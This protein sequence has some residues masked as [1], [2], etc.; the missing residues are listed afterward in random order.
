MVTAILPSMIAPREPA[1]SSTPSR[2]SM[3]IDSHIG[4]PSTSAHLPIT[5]LRLHDHASRSVSPSKK[6]ATKSSPTRLAGFV[7]LFTG[8]GALLALGVFLPLPAIFQ[9]SGLQPGNA[10]VKSYYIVG[11][12]SF[13]VSAICCFGLRNIHGEDHKGWRGITPVKKA[14]DS[15][16]GMKYHGRH[17]LLMRS[18]ESVKLGYVH[19]QLGLGY[20]GGFVARASSVGIS[21]FI[22]LYV[23]AYFMK[24]G[25]CSNLGHGSQDIKSHCRQAYIL[26]AKLTGVSQLVALLFAPVFGYLADGYRRSNVPLLIAALFGIAGYSG[27]AI[28][29]G[30]ESGEEKGSPWIYLIVA[31]L[32]ISQ[33]GAIVCSL[34]L[35]GRCVLGLEVA[36]RSRGSACLDDGAMRVE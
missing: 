3:H 6:T 22:P 9:K 26:A 1:V 29:Q 34:G 18:L 24:S 12:I 8:C 15:A 11:A 23:N 28:L 14:D 21:L 13:V 36:A 5:P 7:G 30:P 16:I 32:G 35:V 17:S 20:F 31:M 4:S 19:P 27:M 10:I 25:L 33:I 2:T